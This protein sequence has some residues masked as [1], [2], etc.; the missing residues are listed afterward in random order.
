MEID[1]SVYGVLNYQQLENFCERMSINAE[2]LKANFDGWRKLILYS[3]DKVFLFPRDPRG[4]KWLDIEI[5]AYEVLNEF[6][7]IPVPVLFERVKDDTISYYEFAM[8]SRLKGTAYSKFEPELPISSVTKMLQ[9]LAN[10]F[11]SWHNIPLESIPQKIKERELFDPKLYEWEI[12]TL[13][14][15][16]LKESLSSTY[17]IL[18][19]YLNKQGHELGKELLS[20]D[21]VD[22]WLYCLEEVVA[23]SPV[24]L[25]SD[26][27]EDQ[28]LIDSEENMKITGILDWET[29]RIGNPVWEFNFFEWG[30]GIW[31]WRENFNDFRRMM[32]NTYLSKRKINL[33]SLEGL[34]LF[35]A[36]SEFLRSLDAPIA[37][38][39]ESIDLSLLSLTEVT[40]KIRKEKK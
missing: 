36:L 16:T 29:A 14:H 11:A 32:W 12:K 5:Q 34:N 20:K 15:A 2:N 19:D 21:T 1:N 39:D 3:D 26:I 38:N 4:V 17:R 23:L 18:E 10:L 7:D 37:K 25:H 13:N 8:V 30:Y 22:L 27:H 35:Y 9:N 33:E 28:I 40:Q 6:N 31:K 24:F